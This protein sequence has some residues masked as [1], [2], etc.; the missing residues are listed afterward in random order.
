MRDN[1]SFAA[2]LPKAACSLNYYATDLDRRAR[3]LKRQQTTL[4]CWKSRRFSPAI[5]FN[6]MT[7]N[8][9]NTPALELLRSLA[10]N[11]ISW[12][13]FFNR[14]DPLDA[15]QITPVASRKRTLVKVIGTIEIGFADRRLLALTCFRDVSGRERTTQGFWERYR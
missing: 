12:L 13:T 6:L 3:S 10:H 2:M 4:F 8:W 15:S 5:F 9:L 1:G 11:K 14:I 7:R